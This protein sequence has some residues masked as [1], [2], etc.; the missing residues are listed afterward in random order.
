MRRLVRS[1]SGSCSWGRPGFS[2]PE[3]LIVIGVIALLISVVLTPLRTARRQAMATRCG[4][5]LQ[6][7][8]V[9]LENVLNEYGYYPVWDDGG[10]PTRYTWIDVLIQRRFLDSARIG[11][12]P[13]DP[14]PAP[15]NQARGRRYKLVYPRTSTP[16]IDYSYGIGVPL[17]SGGWHWQAASAV[18]PRP[19]RFDNHLR[20]T[21][22]RLLAADAHWSAIYNLS[23][24][25]LSTHDWNY[26][27]QYD[28]TVAYRH[29][30]FSAN[31]LFQDGHI[32]RVAYHLKSDPPVNTNQAFVWYPGEPLHVGPEDEHGGNYYPDTPPPIDA[33]GNG[34]GVPRELQPQYYTVNLL[35]TQINHK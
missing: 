24:D 17:A 30:N 33:Y 11:Y 4:T 29:L 35:W 27:T 2:L 16:G 32:G 1:T 15:I 22:N 5:Q 26:P 23:G 14:R 9:A 19:R 28:N 10:T 31:V 3:L 18:D 21:G 12:C 34:L 20:F 25:A 13:E 6:Q 7:I 8:G